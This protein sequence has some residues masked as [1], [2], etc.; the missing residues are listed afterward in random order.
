MKVDWIAFKKLFKVSIPVEEHADYYVDTLARGPQFTHLPALLAEFKEW[1]AGLEI[2]PKQA[3]YDAMNKLI[4]HLKH[5]DAYRKIMSA[6]L[7]EKGPRLDKRS[8]YADG[9]WVVSIDLV[10]ANF[11]TFWSFGLEQET[12]DD[13]CA[14]LDIHPLLVKSKP[15]RQHVFG[16]LNPK[17]NQRFQGQVTR[18][19]WSDLQQLGTAPPILVF[20]EHDELII[21][22]DGD[23]DDLIKQAREAA[24]LAGWPVRITPQKKDRIGGQKECIVTSY[25][26]D[27]LETKVS[28]FGVP[29]NRYMMAFKTHI[30]HET[31]DERDRLFV[32]EGR[33]AMW[34]E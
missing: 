1:Q 15:L 5:T 32:S 13:L 11:H 26:I 29:G 4:E 9:R 12:W 25:D 34:L 8:E 20:I 6:D 16:N 22:N 30:L 21:A 10:A 7:P 23:I 33:I 3:R 2:S 27:T 18:R 17:R 19:I 14:S 31:L 24:S 28:L